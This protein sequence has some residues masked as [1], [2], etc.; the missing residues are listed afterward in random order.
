MTS[1]RALHQQLV[2]KE[3][4]A[5]EIA[6]AALERIQSV[7]P[8]VHSFL[9][10]TAEKALEQAKQIDAKIAAGEAI[11]LLTTCVRREFRPPVL[12]AFCKTLCPLM[13]QR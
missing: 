6:Q 4:S 13:N 7:E 11:G 1:I 10:V 9:H 8:K 3:R 2:K 5:V 12:H